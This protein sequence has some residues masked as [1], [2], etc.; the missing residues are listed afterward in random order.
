MGDLNLEPVPE[1]PAKKKQIA[2]IV[3]AVACLAIAVTLFTKHWLAPAD[4][5]EGG[6]GLRSYSICFQG[7]CEEGTNK[8]LIAEFN[9]RSGK[10]DQ[11]S[12]IFWVMGYAVI[13]VGIF[14]IGLLAAGAALVAKGK[15]F[16]GSVAPA[17]LALLSLFLGLILA[18]IFVATNPTKGSAM[19]LGVGWSFWL[20]GV[21]TVTGIVGAQ[22]LN[23]FKPAPD[24]QI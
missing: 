17:S 24:Y 15:F 14:S 9:R 6:M 23:K 22:M 1:N 10:S 11:K 12:P 20:Y 8:A 19:Q 21:G 3:T 16:L 2:L 4:P 7:E 13:I 18:C 5:L